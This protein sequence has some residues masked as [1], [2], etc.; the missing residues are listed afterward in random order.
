MMA[1]WNVVM[2]IGSVGGCVEDGDMNETAKKILII[3][4][5]LSKWAEVRVCEACAKFLCG[6]IGGCWVGED[7]LW[8]K[9]YEDQ[10]RIA[11]FKCPESIV[12][13]YKPLMSWP[14]V[15]DQAGFTESPRWSMRLAELPKKTNEIYYYIHPNAT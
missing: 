1:S 8:N 14:T 9:L 6:G 11:E 3:A 12:D 5:H 7:E 10:T 2:A 4:F 13:Y 15:D